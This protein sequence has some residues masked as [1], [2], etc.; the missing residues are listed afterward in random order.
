M[1]GPVQEHL[2]LLRGI[3]LRFPEEQRD[4]CALADTDIEVDFFANVAHLQ[5]HRRIKAMQRLVKVSPRFS[6]RKGYST[7]LI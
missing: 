6:N 1:C 2:T 3:G 7:P 4:L 5:M